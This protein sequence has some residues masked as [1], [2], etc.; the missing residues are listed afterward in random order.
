MTTSTAQIRRS[1][2]SFNQPIELPPSYNPNLKETEI[3]EDNRILNTS[4]CARHKSNTVLI[5]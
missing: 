4:G 5:A 3:R 2:L 1:T